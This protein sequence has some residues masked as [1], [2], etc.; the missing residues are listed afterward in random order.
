MKRIQKVVLLAAGSAAL[1]TVAAVIDELRFR[2]ETGRFVQD[3]PMRPLPEQPWLTKL[4]HQLFGLHGSE[5][6]QEA[7]ATQ[8]E[9]SKK[10]EADK[11]NSSIEERVYHELDLHKNK[12]PT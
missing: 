6:R 9:V 5:R 4:Y 7:A 12:A 8:R 10:D 2:E 11:G 1:L 3:H